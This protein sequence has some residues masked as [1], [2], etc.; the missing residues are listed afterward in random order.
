MIFI[1]IIICIILYFR[2]EPIVGYEVKNGSLSTSNV[3][4]GIAL[5]NEEVVH[6]EHY[7]YVNYFAR[8]G[9]RVGSG[10]LV[11]TVDE[12][13]KLNDFMKTASYGENTISSSDLLDIKNQMKDFQQEFE[14]TNFDR[15]YDF[16]YL[17]QG[18]VLKIANYNALNNISALNTAG[19][20]DLVNFCYSNKSGIMSYGID[21]FEDK[22]IQDIKLDDF[23]EKNYEK[24]QLLNNDLVEPGDPIYKM[25]LD[26]NW[27]I[28]IPLTKER[29]AELVDAQYVKVKFLKNQTQSWAQ[30]E[31]ISSLDSVFGVLTFN[32]S[33]LNFVNERFIDIE[34]MTDEEIGLKIPKSSIV[35]KTFYLIP[36]EYITKGG[37]SSND[38]V[39]REVYTENGQSSEFVEVSIYNKTDTEYYIDQS[40][41]RIGDRLLLNDST[42]NYTVSKQGTL[43]GVYNINKGFA[44]FS[45]INI[46]YEN[47]EYAIVKPNT[48]YGLSVYDYIV[49]DANSVNEDDF[50]Y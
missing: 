27:S 45:L 1:Y 48:T 37:K 50:V 43:I 18:S 34:L 36:I 40:S 30:I 21:G 11:Y 10:G 42:A 15:V 26:E 46:L 20:D 32:N 2:S 7:G 13:G 41:L 31:V 35:E 6:S 44:D 16:K 28:V 17:I 25:S 3:Y 8:E 24:K 5:R 4:R 33:M 47:E 39:L 14:S 12:G 9:E 19:I 49:L 23:D 38:G 29:S 22:T